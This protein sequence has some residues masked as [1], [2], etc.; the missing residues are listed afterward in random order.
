[1]AVWLLS[2]VLAAGLC[3]AG[4]RA[5]DGAE[6]PV[7]K[8]PFRGAPV[9]RIGGGT[10][11]I[12]TDVPT[13]QVLAPEHTGHTSRANPVLFWYLASAQP[14][15]VE[16]TLTP[17]EEIEPLVQA[18]LEIAGGTGIHRIQLADYDVSLEPDM[19]YRWTVM[20][21]PDAAQADGAV[22]SS[23]VIRRVLLAE[24]E[25]GRLDRATGEARV[26]AYAAAGLWYDA[27]ESVTE[28]RQADTASIRRQ[29]VW[30]SLLQQAD[31][32]IAASVPGN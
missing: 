17:E 6:L 3:L 1:M 2:L 7:Y 23:A 24:D 16:F 26:S 32:S 5:D 18:T 21:S 28:S 19:S 9:T 4:V 27:L 15:Q 25:K 12:A 8:P 22:F 30:H 31:L 13:V 10:R 11:G 20:V 14:V 29:Q